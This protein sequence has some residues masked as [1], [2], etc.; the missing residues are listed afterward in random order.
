M[1][2]K[3]IRVLLVEDSS[4]D[5]QLVQDLLKE[6]DG[7][8]YPIQTAD[9]LKGG[10]D[11]LSHEP[12]DIILLDLSL[13]DSSPSATFPALHQKS[14]T[15]PIVVMTGFN[16]MNLALESVQQGCQDYLV[17]GKFDGDML[18][19]SIR[20]AIER[21]R[22]VHELQALSIHDSLTGL[23]NRR[24]F[25]SLVEHH[26]KMARRTQKGFFIFFADVDGLKKINDTFGHQEGDCALT[27]ISR[28][29]Q[30]TFR[31]SDIVARIGGDEFAVLAL[32]DRKDAA[33]AMA[34]RLR[35]NLQDYHEK[36]RLKYPLS[37]SLGFAYY[38]PAS[39]RA[40]EALLAEADEA[41]YSQKQSRLKGRN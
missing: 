24:S 6:S 38:N 33:E 37:F 21:Q 34:G 36:E 28:V 9:T 11:S 18:V 5:A 12:F 40:I 20:Y 4:A 3:Q 16:D 2:D 25:F 8:D 15:T 14:P 39:P 30:G 27:S 19:R 29:L 10:L 26:E 13:P 17:K 23:H 22:L 41:M 32:D 7:G 1:N 35:K 31:D